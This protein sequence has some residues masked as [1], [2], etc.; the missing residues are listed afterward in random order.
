MTGARSGWRALRPVL[1]AGAATLTWLT[2]SSP[3][4]SADTLSDSSSLLGS[5]T[6][7]ASSLTGTLNETLPALSLIAEHDPAPAA[8]HNGLLQPVVV[9]VSGAVDDLITSIP[10]VNHVVPAG[11]V[12]V[13]T[14]PVTAVADDVVA[15]AVGTVVPP[16]VDAVPVLEPVVEPVTDLVAG[17]AQLPEALPQ[18]PIAPVDETA[19]EASTAS[20]DD[21]TSAAIEDASA[22]VE[23]ADSATDYA[24]ETDKSV[25]S[26][27]SPTSGASNFSLSAVAGTGLQPL[28]SDFSLPS[29]RLPYPAQAPTP[30]ASGSGGSSASAAGPGPAAW[31]DSFSLQLPL[32]GTIPLGDYSEHAPSPVSFDP[33]SSPD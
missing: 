12:S 25:V 8:P 31:V 30:P 32:T 15:G 20:A 4:A 17:D 11:T 27:V 33:G 22:Q 13:V 14:A 6:S 28:S 9:P 10:L 2:F 23:S 29:D 7:S 21:L 5:V 19:G 18:L 26:A 16:L 1:L 24:M 3:A